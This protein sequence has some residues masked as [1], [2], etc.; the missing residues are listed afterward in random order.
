MIVRERSWLPLPKIR[1]EHKAGLLVSPK[2]VSFVVMG[3]SLHYTK[4]CSF[5]SRLSFY[6]FFSAFCQPFCLTYQ[7]GSA[8]G[9]RVEH[10]PQTRV[11]KSSMSDKAIP[12]QGPQVSVT[13][14]PVLIPGP[15]DEAQEPV[16][17]SVKPANES[18][19]T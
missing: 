8:S 18:F 5:Y 16:F 13:H 7:F 14:S 2:E 4:D 19:S 9:M 6:V 3:Q 15:G 1:K 11:L 12:D 10:K 17:Q